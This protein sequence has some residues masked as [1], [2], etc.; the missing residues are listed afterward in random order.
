MPVPYEGRLLPY[1]GSRM[2]EH[3]GDVITSGGPQTLQ[4]A[5]ALDRPAVSPRARRVLGHSINSYGID[6][7]GAKVYTFNSL[8]YRGPEPREGAAFR[9]FACGCSNTFGTG[10]NWEETW[11]YQFANRLAQQRKISVDQVDLLNFSQGGASQDYISRTL[12]SQIARVKPDLV[13]AG[14]TFRDR[15]EIASG[16]VSVAIM[17][18]LLEPVLKG[19]IH[20][21]RVAHR[22]LAMSDDDVIMYDIK[23]ILLVSYCCAVRQ[24]PLVFCTVED[25][26]HE[27]DET[28]PSRH[29]TVLS[30]PFVD[31][32]DLRMLAEIRG[33]RVDIAADGKHPGP[34]S[35]ENIAAAFW[36]TYEELPEA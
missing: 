32:I 2:A 23:N 24:V 28:F 1:D 3:W 8:G 13:L 26:R 35:N 5:M 16:E 34:R 27:C 15:F 7:S 14:F 33:A 4:D 6:R 25:L 29:R 30:S 9:I 12:I 21:D 10:L 20:Y 17:P 36:K 11:P 18:Q 22:V 31:E 19:T